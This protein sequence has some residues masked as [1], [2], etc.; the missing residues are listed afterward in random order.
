[1]TASFETSGTIYYPDYIAF[2]FNPNKIRIITVNN[3]TV[4]ISD[5]VVSYKD[6][7]SAYNNS[8]EF[9]IAKYL[10]SFF[11]SRAIVTS[12]IISVKVET[13]DDVFNFDMLCIWGAMNIG[14]V[15][16]VSRKVVWFRK[17]PF[18]FSMYIHNGAKLR[19]RY[20]STQYVQA[21]AL[22][23]G[24]VHIDPLSVFPDAERFG[25]IRLDEEIISSVFDYT[26]D[27][28]FR[29]VGD[30]TIINR[31]VI[32]DS[33]CGI[34]IRWIDRHGFYQY[35]LFH[36]GDQI[37]Q[38]QN[39]GELL[40]LDHEGISYCYGV[41]RY[42]GKEIQVMMKA[43]AVLVDMD[44]FE[45]LLT[46][47]TSPIVDLYVSGDW[48]PVNIQPVTITTGQ[49]TLQ[50]FEINIILPEIISQIL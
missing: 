45:M 31:L 28:T 19:K 18:T 20:D 21:E 12:K 25:V 23:V 6:I 17:F 29:P 38:T 32:D 47:I 10:Q 42:Q 24:L 8:V 34:Y 26:F 11:N 36:R 4:T 9:D 16:N 39:N 40:S 30:G 2:C 49:K 41:S 44:T 46:L 50:D 35:Y 22:G 43:C 14:E 48:I 1:M 27:N 3:V 15:F 5:G 33:E 13:K 37:Q 7:R